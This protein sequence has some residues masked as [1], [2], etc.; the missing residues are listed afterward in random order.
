MN[1]K[2]KIDLKIFSNILTA[3]GFCF[4]GAYVG[5][6]Y[7]TPKQSFSLGVIINNDG[8]CSKATMEYRCASYFNKCIF[9]TN[10]DTYG[11]IGEDNYYKSKLTDEECLALAKNVYNK[12]PKIL[13]NIISYEYYGTDIKYSNWSDTK[14]NCPDNNLESRMI[15]KSYKCNRVKLDN[16]KINQ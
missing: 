14:P 1:K 3:L 15:N 16:N 5:I 7:F 2:N 8:T 4:I 6:T 12:E 9:Y 10:N 13:E 11:P